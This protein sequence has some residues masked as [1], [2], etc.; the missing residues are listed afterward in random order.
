[1]QDEGRC[2]VVFI[3]VFDDI[4]TDGYMAGYLLQGGICSIPCH[5]ISRDL[6]PQERSHMAYACVQII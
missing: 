5:L 1:M 4:T 2:S 3:V 6:L